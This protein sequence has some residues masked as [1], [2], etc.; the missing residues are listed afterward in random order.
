MK[1]E[2]LRAIRG[3][4]LRACL[5]LY[6]RPTMLSM[7][8]WFCQTIGSD[9]DEIATELAYFEG[10]GWIRTAEITIIGRKDTKID[11]TPDGVD[12][13]RGIDPKEPI[14]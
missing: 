8:D 4:I 10:R 1:N 7:L 11:L 13:A 9:R 12:T 14:L 2:R 5:E 6:P 3:A